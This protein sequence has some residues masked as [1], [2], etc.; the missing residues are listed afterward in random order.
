MGSPVGEVGRAD[1]ETQ[2]EVTLS[3]SYYLGVYEVTQGQY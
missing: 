1:N 3:K 2:H